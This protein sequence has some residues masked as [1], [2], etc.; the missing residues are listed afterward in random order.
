MSAHTFGAL[1][2]ADTR[3]VWR[4][5]LLKWVLLLPIGLAL[6]LR[7]LIPRAHD[8]LLVFAGFE[9]APYY[10]LVMGGYLMTASGIVGMVVGFL[11]LDEQDAHTLTALRV[12]P[13]S[14]RRYLAY[15]VTVPLLVANAS[16]LLGYSIIGITPLPFSALLAISAV[17][18]LSAPLLALV[19]ATAA[20]NKVAG[21]AV[22]KVLNG[23]NLLPIAAFFLP[24]P[25]Q[26]VAGIIPTYWP[27]RAFWSAAAGEDY[28]ACLAIGATS[29][30]LA[31][32]L[33]ASMFERR[34]ARRG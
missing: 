33:A 2:Y 5:P 10:P 9:A 26:Y 11:L 8:A 30:A 18:A 1:A 3:L 15:R 6:L 28:L 13:L 4:D 23:L 19:L 12:T 17:G 14:M 31:L 22:V 34:L 25:L 27:M 7:A 21:L 16:T 32:L 20:P 29:C 24:T